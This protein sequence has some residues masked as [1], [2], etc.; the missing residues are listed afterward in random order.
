MVVL[1]GSR[2]ALGFFRGVAVSNAREIARAL[3]PDA[4]IKGRGREE[5]LDS[6][7]R[8]PLTVEKSQF[9]ASMWQVSERLAGQY[10]LSLFSRTPLDQS[11]IDLNHVRARVESDV[12][13][14]TRVETNQW[15]GAR[16]QPG[17]A[18]GVVELLYLGEA[19]TLLPASRLDY[20]KDSLVFKA[21]ERVA[22]P[23]ISRLVISKTADS[24]GY[25]YSVTQPIH[26]N[27]DVELTRNDLQN[28]MEREIGCPFPSLTGVAAGMGNL[29]RSRQLHPVECDVEEADGTKTRYRRARGVQNPGSLAVED[30]IRTWNINSGRYTTNGKEAFKVDVRT[31]TFSFSRSIGANRAHEL[32]NEILSAA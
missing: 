23:V 2:L 3:F 4:G 16:F 12:W 18:E 7:E 9:L 24:K 26:Q 20:D 11:V 22:V 13:L 31:S 5:L 21:Y 27:A 10:H 32:I 19:E 28:T 6:I 30:N 29:V 25:I 1:D 14:P 17:S 8:Q 15:L